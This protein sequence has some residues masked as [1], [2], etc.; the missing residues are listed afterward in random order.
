MAR[1]ACFEDFYE[2]VSETLI[3][4]NVTRGYDC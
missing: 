4:N 2:K 3:E 1:K